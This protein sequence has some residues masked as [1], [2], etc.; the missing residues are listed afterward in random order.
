M[1]RRG[2]AVVDALPKRAAA[3][4]D[5][6]VFLAGGVPEVCASPSNWRARHGRPDRGKE[7]P[8]TNIDAWEPRAAVPR[9]VA[10]LRERD[11]VDQTMYH[12]ARTAAR[13]A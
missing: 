1:S 9:S 6:Q 4:C 12:E 2:A 5:V 13:G 11:G 7:S 3:F 8:S 10:G